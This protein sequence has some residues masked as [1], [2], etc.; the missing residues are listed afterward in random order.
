MKQKQLLL[1]LI[2]GLLLVACGGDD[3]SNPPPET[4][5][6]TGLETEATISASNAES[7]VRKMFGLGDAAIRLSTATDEEAVEPKPEPYNILIPLALTETIERINTENTIASDAAAK[8]LNIVT[9]C[10]D[11]LGLID[12]TITIDDITG[13]FNGAMNYRDCLVAGFTLNGLADISGDYDLANDTFLKINLDFSWFRGDSET[14]SYEAADKISVEFIDDSTTTTT[15]TD[16]VV[17]IDD[18]PVVKF[19]DYAITVTQ[20]ESGKTLTLSGIF[21][22]PTYGFVTLT[23]DGFLSFTADDIWPYFGQ[24][25]MNGD[26]SSLRILLE[27]SERYTLWVDEDGDGEYETVDFVD[28][29]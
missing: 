8:N 3:E 10:E 29:L 25:N 7:L 2:T 4:P 22:H 5:V 14:V 16:Y 24:V 12:Y 27:D 23:T 13:A 20:D 19:E 17:T 18:L 1:S 28:W 15:L 26:A 21:Y 6:Y 11:D 9:N